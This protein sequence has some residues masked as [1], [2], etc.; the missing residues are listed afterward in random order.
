MLQAFIIVL[1]EG[2]EAFLIVAIIFAYLRKTG[3]RW[4]LPAVYAAIAASAGASL[5]LSYVLRMGVNQSFWEGVLGVVAII[6]VV[7]LVI[8]MWRTAPRLN[9]KMQARLSEVSSRSSHWAAFLGVFFFTLLM[10]TREG[11]E[12]ALLLTQ[13][14]GEY[15]TGGLLGLGAATAMALVWARFGHLI[16][17]KRFFQVTGIFLLLFTVQIAIYSFHEFSEAGLFP[18]SDALH[19]AT[20]LY[21]PDGLYGRWFSLLIVIVCGVWLAGAW[22]V[23]RFR[24]FQ[25]EPPAMKGASGD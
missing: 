23:D 14:R 11:M 21:S 9:Q 10:I 15:L 8:H 25:V 16:N 2:F 20:E 12:T 22:V 24:R 19:E 3:Q 17:L 7:S 1:R 4:L 13:V 18:N 5:A 6:F